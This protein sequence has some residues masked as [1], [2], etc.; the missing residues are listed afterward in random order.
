MAKSRKAN[1][2]SRGAFATATAPTV[3]PASP[4][5]SHP[6]FV[7]YNAYEDRRTYHPLRAFR[8]AFS[9]KRSAARLVAKEPL[10][11]PFRRFAA[12]TKA[13]IAFADP[14]KVMICVR[15]RI[16]RRVINAV[17]VAGKPVFRPKK[18]RGFSNVRC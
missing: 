3:R 13:T 15:R 18:R 17:G 2:R 16:R 6:N 5:V 4:F 11:R 12:Q 9:I 10:T 7:G 1:R 8:P 14:S